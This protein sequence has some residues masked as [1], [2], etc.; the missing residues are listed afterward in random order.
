MMNL[1]ITVDH[2]EY[3]GAAS[4]ADLFYAK[5]DILGRA[6]S[7]TRGAFFGIPY[8]KSGT[9]LWDRFANTVIAS[10]GWVERS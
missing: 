8:D 7:L 1:T 4:L 3:N 6:Q 5:R 2:I 9:G 10:V